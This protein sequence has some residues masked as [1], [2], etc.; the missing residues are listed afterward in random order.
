ML[1]SALM[2]F[3]AIASLY[4][5]PAEAACK[6]CTQHINNKQCKEVHEDKVAGNTGC[7]TDFYGNCT[8]SGESCK[9]GEG[10]GTQCSPEGECIDKLGR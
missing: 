2:I 6:Y 9:Y 4:P 8:Y 5:S 7:E 10:G 1:K 3:F